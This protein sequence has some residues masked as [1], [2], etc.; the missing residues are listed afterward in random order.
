MEWRRDEDGKENKKRDMDKGG[1][2]MKEGDERLRR[3]TNEEHRGA[4]QHGSNK[5]R[6]YK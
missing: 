5:G 1:K 6:N 3:K 4:A 2:R